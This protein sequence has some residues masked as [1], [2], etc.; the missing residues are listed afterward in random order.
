MVVSPSTPPRRSAAALPATPPPLAHVPVTHA[1]MLMRIAELTPWG[2]LGRHDEGVELPLDKNDAQKKLREE[3]VK[4]FAATCTWTHTELA[5]KF[6]RRELTEGH[7]SFVVLKNAAGTCQVLFLNCHFLGTSVEEAAPRLGMSIADLA[8]I[9]PKNEADKTANPFRS[10]HDALERPEHD[11]V[12]AGEV[13]VHA[14]APWEWNCRSGHHCKKPDGKFTED[15]VSGEKQLLD[16]LNALCGQSRPRALTLS[17]IAMRPSDAAACP[18]DAAER[19]LPAKRRREEREEREEATSAALFGD[20]PPTLPTM[21]PAT[22]AVDLRLP[23][24]SGPPPLLAAGV[25]PLAPPPPAAA[26]AAQSVRRA[27]F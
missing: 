17:S 22:A 16:I 7:F 11:I 13:M 10:F 21:Q 25:L 4:P 8:E 19:S 26:A 3:K 27:L 9:V 23:R 18:T 5:D 1:D 20:T 15:S 6:A 2:R 12:F 24:R 14:A